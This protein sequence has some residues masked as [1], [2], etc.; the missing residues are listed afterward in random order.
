MQ[1]NPDLCKEIIERVLDIHIDSL[2]AIEVESEGSSIIRRGV[3]FDVFVKSENAAFEVEMQSY[4]Q[5]DLPQRMRF[6]RA[7]LDRRLLDKGDGYEKL[8]PVYVIFICTHDP[9]G[10][11]IPVYT[12]E[13]ACKEDPRVPFDN[14]AVDIVLNA[15][16]DLGLARPEVASLLQFVGTNEASGADSLAL[17][18]SEAVRH[19]H[20]DEEWIENM[21]WIE[22]DI[23]DAKRYAAE[24]AAEKAREAALAEGLAEGRE[25]GHAEGLEQ[26]I[27]Q[28]L[29]QGFEQGIEQ[30]LE[31]GLAQ[32]ITTADELRKK[33]LVAMEDSG[34]TSEEIIAMLKAE[35]LE[36]L[37]EKY[38]LKSHSEIS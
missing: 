11:G 36:D 20:E 5:R 2:E 34:C 23:E 14:G 8:R 32:G 27:E 10:F 7:Q 28:G 15:R 6:Y 37:C 31:Q 26:G 3:R 1:D 4:E 25:K 30:G 24:K 12:F 38:G 29:Q 18:L 21:S 13:S 33:L 17:D 35:N 9:F 22:W 19:A 16:G